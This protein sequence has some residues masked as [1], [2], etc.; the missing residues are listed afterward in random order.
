MQ[1]FYT[2]N[3]QAGLPQP[4]GDLSLGGYVSTDQIPDALLSNLFDQVSLYGQRLNKAEYRVIALF[5]E[6]EATYANL[7]VWIEHFSQDSDEVFAGVFQLGSAP[8]SADACGDLYVASLGNAQAAPRGVTL[9]SADSQGAALALPD[10]EA[11]MY[12]ALYL[13][14]SLDPTFLAPLSDED[15]VAI[16]DGILVLPTEEEV[17]VQFTWD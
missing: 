12:L 6:T 1:F 8:F 13:K 2:G 9:V 14:R 4:Q 17:L 15:L 3:K 7:K 16:R 11:G 10:L 5:N